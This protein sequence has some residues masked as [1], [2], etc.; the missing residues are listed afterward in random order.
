MTT[1]IDNS[2][3][4]GADNTIDTTPSYVGATTVD[5]QTETVTTSKTTEEMLEDAVVGQLGN[6]LDMLPSDSGDTLTYDLLSLQNNAIMSTAATEV[7]D[8]ISGTV[9]KII[10]ITV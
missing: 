8:E 5:L 1:I 2:V 9:T 7:S 6:I 3:F 10:D 4:L